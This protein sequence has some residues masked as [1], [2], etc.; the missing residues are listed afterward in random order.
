MA[1]GLGV[2]EA[3]AKCA[4]KSKRTVLFNFFGSEEQGVAGSDYYCEHPI[5]LLD[6][7]LVFINMEGPGVGDKIAKG[8]V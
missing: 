2:A 8:R 4:V 5:Y 7:T 3:L 1:V 6:K